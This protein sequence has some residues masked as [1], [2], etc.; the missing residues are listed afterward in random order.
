MDKSPKEKN[1]NNENRKQ[2]VARI[3]P[4]LIKECQ[5]YNKKQEAVLLDGFI[6]GG[7]SEREGRFTPKH[8]ERPRP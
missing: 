8:T 2:Y 6:P 7:G 1:T 5:K 3:L 4:D